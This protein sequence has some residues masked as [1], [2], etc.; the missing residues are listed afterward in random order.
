[1]ASMTYL[2]TWDKRRLHRFEKLSEALN[3]TG[4]G[5]LLNRTASNL[6]LRVEC[7]MA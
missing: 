7:K 3:V 4:S 6:V 2:S 1:M 5:L